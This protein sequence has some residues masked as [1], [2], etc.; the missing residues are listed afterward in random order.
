LHAL[1]AGSSSGYCSSYIISSRANLVESIT[2]FNSNQTLSGYTSVHSAI[3]FVDNIG[4][5]CFNAFSAEISYEHMTTL[6]DPWYTIPLN[7]VYN[8]GNMWVDVINYTFYTPET[9]PSG[10]WAFFLVYTIG[11]FLMRFVYN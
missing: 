3:G 7:V 8:L 5:A 4:A 2:N 10:D 11:D 6:F 1:P 9:V